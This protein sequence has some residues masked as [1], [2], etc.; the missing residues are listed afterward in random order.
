MKIADIIKCKV[1]RFPKG[2]VFT[3]ADFANDVES[4][5]EL[6]KVLNRLAASGEIAK[7]AKGKYYKPEPSPFGELAPSQYQVVKDLLER[8]GKIEGY[9]TG[10]SVYNT[11]GLTTQVSS[12]IQIGK[13]EIRSSMK[14]GKYSISFVK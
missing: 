2:Y 4:K 7:L 14:R 1:G 13:N 9:L 5:E 10:L 3:Y 8:N 11:L 12:S 6:V